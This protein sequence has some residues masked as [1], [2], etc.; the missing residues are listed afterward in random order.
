MPLTEAQAAKL[1]EFDLW[2]LGE[3]DITAPQRED[4]VAAAEWLEQDYEAAQARLKERH[5]DGDDRDRE[6]AGR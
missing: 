6:H 3:Y 4:V 2:A 1:A 5:D